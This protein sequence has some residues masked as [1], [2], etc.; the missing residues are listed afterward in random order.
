[1]RDGVKVGDLLKLYKPNYQ[2]K[3][4]SKRIPHIEW[5][6]TDFT[7]DEIKRNRVVLKAQSSIPSIRANPSNSIILTL[8]F[9]NY[10]H[11]LYIY[12]KDKIIT[13]PA[14]DIGVE[15]EKRVVYLIIP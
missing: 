10:T 12:L 2:L 11:P 13:L 7:F 4:K 3:V 14:I 6:I 8:H 1:M 15:S 5:I 9:F